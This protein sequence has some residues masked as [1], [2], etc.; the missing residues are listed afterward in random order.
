MPSRELVVIGGW[1]NLRLD[2]GEPTGVC[3]A[4]RFEEA[5]AGAAR[6]WRPVAAASPAPAPLEQAPPG[7]LQL[8]SRR[9]A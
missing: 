6:R 9:R 3:R 7:T 5:E 2:V 4:C 1:T 8:R